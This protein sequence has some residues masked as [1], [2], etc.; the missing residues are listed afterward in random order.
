LFLRSYRLKQILQQ[1]E[2]AD[3]SVIKLFAKQNKD[4]YTLKTFTAPFDTPQLQLF[5]S[6]TTI[7]MNRWRIR[8]WSMP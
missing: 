2:F 7:A 8:P 5:F 3:I 6:K 4:M 1:S